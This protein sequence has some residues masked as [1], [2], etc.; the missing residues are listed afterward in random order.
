[1]K[2][3]GFLWVLSILSVSEV[4]SLGLGFRFGIVGRKSILI[5]GKS[6]VKSSNFNFFR[7]GF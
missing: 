6:K 7:S 5:G 4:W 2:A 1:M 3:I